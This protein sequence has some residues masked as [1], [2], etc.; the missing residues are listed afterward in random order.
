MV[1]GPG[2]YVPF[3][4]LPFQLLCDIF[5]YS[6]HLCKS[7]QFRFGDSKYTRVM[8]HRPARNLHNLELTIVHYDV[9]TLLQQTRCRC[10]GWLIAGAAPAHWALKDNILKMVGML[11]YFRVLVGKRAEDCRHACQPNFKPGIGR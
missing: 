11:G 10:A 8:A 2:G 1:A 6:L 5:L 7:F 4:L 3:K 9:Q